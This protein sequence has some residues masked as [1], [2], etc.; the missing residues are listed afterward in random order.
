VGVKVSRA[1]TVSAESA[2]FRAFQVQLAS[3]VAR[4]HEVLQALVLKVMWVCAVLR[5]TEEIRVLRVSEDQR[6]LK[7]IK[8]KWVHLHKS[9][10][11][12]AA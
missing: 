1:A 8:V 11:P 9:Q 3:Q 4:V 6:D 5:V 10:V 2:V 12:K 7:E